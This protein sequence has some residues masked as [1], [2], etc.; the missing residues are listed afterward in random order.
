M[1]VSSP[2]ASYPAAQFL[3]LEEV[4]MR[5]L[6][7]VLI[8][9]VLLSASTSPDRTK[10][11]MVAVNVVTITEVRRGSEIDAVAGLGDL[12]DALLVERPFGAKEGARS[13]VFAV[14]ADGVFV[15]RVAVEYG[16]GTPLLIQIVNGLSLGDRIIVSDMSAWDAF[17]ELRLGMR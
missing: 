3:P 15:R 14:D 12:R 9:I 16:R 4:A 13:S 10:L 8:F 1:P 6:I 5:T 2:V 7:A 11:P 17:E